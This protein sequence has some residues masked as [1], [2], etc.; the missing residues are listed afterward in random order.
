MAPLRSSAAKAALALLAACAIAAMLVLFA[1]HAVRADKASGTWTGQVDARGNYY[2]ER[3][4][5]VVAPQLAAQVD[6][7]NGVRARGSYLVDAITSASV[8]AGALV[9]NRFTEI[10]HDVSLGTG[11]EFDLGDVMLD[12]N[13]DGHVSVE[14][15]YLSRAGTLSGTLWLFERASGLQFSGTYLVDDVKSVL[16]GPSGPSGAANQGQ[17]KSTVLSL[18]WVQA[19]SPQASLTVGYDLG[20]MSGFLQ[21]PYR[22]VSL[23]AAPLPETHPGD[24]TRHTLSGRFQYY[25]P[26]TGTALH[27]LLRLYADSW[28]IYGI[29]PEARVY[30]RI[31][32]DFMLRLRYRFYTQ[33]N[34]FFQEDTYTPADRYYTADPKMTRFQNHLLGAQLYVPLT[35]LE[36]TA[37]DFAWRASLD[38]S[39][40]YLWSTN[41]FGNAT[42][43][44]AGLA[45]PF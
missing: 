25:L 22:S 23:G 43:A 8:A 36:R 9:D 4:T 3:S 2:W 32:G 34:A 12:L 1:P 27:A 15:D 37:L 30:Q 35:F 5:R 38:F 44:Q 17:L 10:R 41:A 21:N 11:Y 40:E 7:P 39:F 31:S 26:S 19:L 28:D 33:T 14:P 13:L 45:I 6:A 42:I 16:R 29:T 20:L 18:G 24:R